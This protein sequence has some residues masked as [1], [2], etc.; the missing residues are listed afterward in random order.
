MDNPPAACL[1]PRTLLYSQSTVSASPAGAETLTKVG[2]ETIEWCEEVV[3][4]GEGLEWAQGARVDFGMC[5]FLVATKP[6]KLMR[7]WFK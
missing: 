2:F 1:R 4:E 5:H 3:S 7:K 6:S